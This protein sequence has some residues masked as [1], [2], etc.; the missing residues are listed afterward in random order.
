MIVVAGTNK[1]RSAAEQYFLQIPN[2]ELTSLKFAYVKS[3]DQ[4][5]LFPI[6]WSAPNGVG[7]E[8]IET[9]SFLWNRIVARDQVSI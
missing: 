7:R 2:A 8:H 3:P 5:L 4:N 1:Y 6:N 9:K